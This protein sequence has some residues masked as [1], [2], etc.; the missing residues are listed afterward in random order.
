MALSV[1]T[2]ALVRVAFLDGTE[3][4]GRLTCRVL[5]RLKEAIGVIV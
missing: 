4:V 3:W 1:T 2:D 5:I